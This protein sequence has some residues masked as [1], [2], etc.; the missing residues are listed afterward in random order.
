VVMMR[1]GT[2]TVLSMQNNYEGP[3]ADFAMVV[4]VP[5]VLQQDDVRTLPP[6]IFDRVDALAAPR[7]VEYWEQDPC[8]VEEIYEDYGPPP[9]PTSVAEFSAKRSR[10]SRDLGVTVEA[11][12]AVG[13]YDIVILSAKDSGG[14]DTWLRREKYKIPKG[15]ANVLRPYVAS[16]MKFFVAKVNAK[17]VDVSRGKVMLSPLRF[18]YDS[19]NFSLPIRLGMLNANGPQ[20]LIVHILAREVRYAVANYDNRAIPT[21]LEV[22][23]ATRDKFGQFYASLFDRVLEQHPKSVITEYAWSAGS[24]DPC[25]TEVLSM[26]EL[27]KLGADVLPT[28]QRAL[29]GRAPSE[30]R[31]KMPSDF[32]L[33]RLHARY[34]SSNLGEDLIFRAAD[35]IAGGRETV[36]ADGQLEQGA[37]PSSMN[38]FQARYAIRHRW[39][40]LVECAEPRYGI[41]GGPPAELQRAV[42]P[43]SPAI[44]RDL[45]FVDRSAKLESFL[46]DRV[47]ELDDGSAPKLPHGSAQA[48]DPD[49]IKP[50]RG[51]RSR[52]ESNRGAGCAGC[53]G[54]SQ[55]P[56]AALGVSF[57]LLAAR[58]RRR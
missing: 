21:N 18:H 40:G 5:V 53:Q 57:F 41:W 3:P 28:Y 8:Y 14:L 10:A 19:K 23:D 32:V 39:E 26:E 15:A 44:A 11:Q 36:G 56:I 1:D 52:G 9:A 4:P 48:P 22:S 49:P 45:A 29:S 42:D 6:E 54:D 50:L 7:L 2:R 34:D 55:P 20:D 33:T 24:C 25:P 46:T 16:G 27:S 51:G 31:W 12:F 37:T 43:N 58:R 30:L 47:V 35:G 17:K 38:N 13:E